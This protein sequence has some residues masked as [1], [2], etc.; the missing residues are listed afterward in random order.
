MAKFRFG[1]A[2]PAVV[3]LL[4]GLGSAAAGDPPP[5][6]TMLAY[7]PHQ[8]GIDI[9]T[10]TESETAACKVELEPGRKT[11]NKQ[12]T[13][14]VLKDG[15]GRVLRK[16]HDT[17]GDGPVNMFAYYKDGEEVYREIDSNGN[18][19]V[20]QYRWV[21]PSGHKWGADPDEDGKIDYWLAISPEELSQELLAAIVTKDQKRFEALLMTKADL[22]TLGLAGAELERVQSKLN[23]AAAQFQKTCQDLGKLSAD[24]VWVHLETKVP[25]TTPADVLGAKTD[26]VRYRHAAILYQEGDGK[27]A[28]HNWIQTGEVI[29]VGRAW[30]LIQGPVPGVQQPDQEVR[31][32]SEGPG[33]IPIPAGAEKLIEQLNK[34]DQDG[35][36]ETGRQGVIKF[37]TARAEIIQKIAALYTKPEDRAKQE[38]WLRQVADCWAAA[39]QQGDAASLKRLTEWRGALAKDRASTL[40]PY[41]VFREISADYAQQLPGRSRD[42]DK[43]NKLQDEW[44][45]KLT[46]F[47]ADYPAADDTPDALMQLGVVNEFFGP[48]MEPEAKAAYAKLVKSFPKH[49][50]ARRAQGCLDRLSL[51]GQVLNLAGPVL[52]GGAQF[53]IKSLL[54]KAV[55]V[56]YWASWNE[57][58]ASDFEK[59]KLALKPFHGKAELVC[60]NL[61]YGAAEAIKFLKANPME[62]THVHLPG[63]LESPLAVQYGITALPVMFLVGPDGK[64]V[65]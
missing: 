58:A 9:S 49:V 46:R 35:P 48:K 4:A 7:K 34:H 60:V 19:K 25:Q 62:G 8:P 53:N 65:S 57:M 10:P 64:V 32:P 44:K 15:Q 17:T 6:S 37:N 22:E 1:F 26:L 27:S 12:A 59:I 47:V 52:G 55:V 36:A 14:W 2:L 40:L 18:G 28:K 29:Q 3:T 39:A 33:T 21:G 41:V 42:Q 11:G 54:G 56:Y 23:G 43:L 24:T 63:G 13:A 31:G 50:L 16:F 20:D 30:K 45:E 38:V 5:V 61:D 51:E